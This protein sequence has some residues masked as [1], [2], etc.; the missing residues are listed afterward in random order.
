[1]QDLKTKSAR[2]LIKLGL[3]ADAATYIGL[4][5]AALSGVCIYK[6]YFLWAAAFLTISGALDL[7]DGA[8]ARASGTKSIFGGILDSSL[9][10][11]GDG[12]VLSGILFYCASLGEWTYTALALSALLG[13]FSI[14]YVRARAECEI[15]SCKVGFWERGERIVYVILGLL[16]DNLGVVLWV[17][18]T[19][20]H[21]TALF[22]L[23]YA[24]RPQAFPLYQSGK[25]TPLGNFIFHTSGR[26]SSYYLIKAGLLFLAVA[27]IRI[28]I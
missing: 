8:I 23:A 20:T 10:R 1:M 26:Q 28:G 3:T 7:M 19:A 27:F 13:S 24:G 11:Y 25:D 17:L 5:F 22:R 16:F 2:Y 14:S 18:G 12:F 21:L 9:D 15:D 4:F 6:G